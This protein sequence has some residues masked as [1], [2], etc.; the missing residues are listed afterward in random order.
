MHPPPLATSPRTGLQQ[1]V[2][3]LDDV[4]AFIQTMRDASIPAFWGPGMLHH[5]TVWGS[6]FFLMG[7]KRRLA[8]FFMVLEQ[9]LEMGL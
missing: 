8:T 6:L 3:Y 4:L 9:G 5:E 2:F 7:L 1:F